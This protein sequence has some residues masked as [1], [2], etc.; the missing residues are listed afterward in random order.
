MTQTPALVRLWDKDLNLLATELAVPQLTEDGMSITVSGDNAFCAAAMESPVSDDLHLTVDPD[1]E[2]PSVFKNRWGGSVDQ[3][4]I[5]DK[6]CGCCGLNEIA[7]TI[8]AVPN[9]PTFTSMTPLQVVQALI[10]IHYARL[11]P[12][13]DAPFD[14]DISSWLGET[15]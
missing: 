12:I 1:I 5:T 14:L 7:T 15:S 9:K 13:P 2:N 4:E 11:Y 8:K 6:R 10:A 3:I